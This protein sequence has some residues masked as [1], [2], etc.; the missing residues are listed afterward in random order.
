MLVET[1]RLGAGRVPGARSTTATGLSAL[2]VGRGRSWLG[3]DVG[4][5]AGLGRPPMRRARLAAWAAGVPRR[6]APGSLDV[7]GSVGSADS[8]GSVDWVG[9]ADSVGSVG[10]VIG[11]RSP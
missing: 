9:S 8:V 6:S 5:G 7:A 2:G 4:A 10:S 3:T 1:L 11:I